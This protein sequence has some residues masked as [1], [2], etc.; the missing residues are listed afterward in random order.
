MAH[1]HCRVG[2]LDIAEQSA[3]CLSVDIHTASPLFLAGTRVYPPRSPAISATRAAPSTNPHVHSLLN[4]GYLYGLTNNAPAD[5]P[6]L[7]PRLSYYRRASF[8]PSTEDFSILTFLFST[9]VLVV[10]SLNLF[11]KEFFFFFVDLFRRE[12]CLISR[13][14]L[15]SCGRIYVGLGE[16]ITGSVDW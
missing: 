14:A 12:K 3:A 16:I 11:R 9:V 8:P 7:H 4:H 6:P 13:P 10:A 1:C 15:R 2:S 5:T